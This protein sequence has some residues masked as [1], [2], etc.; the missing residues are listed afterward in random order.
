MIKINFVSRGAVG[1]L[2]E[3][4]TS[5]SAKSKLKRHT[6]CTDNQ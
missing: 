2:V 4:M 1:L 5:L 6:P 3:I